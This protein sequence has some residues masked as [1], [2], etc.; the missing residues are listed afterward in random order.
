M[1]R[2]SSVY[3]K[4]VVLRK[5]QINRRN[6]HRKYLL[7][8]LILMRIKDRRNGRKIRRLY[9][10]IK[11]DWVLSPLVHRHK[12]RGRYLISLVPT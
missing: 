2:I 3:S 7:L 5:L 8:L 6:I 4:K 9:L 11:I 12:R 1:L 10:K